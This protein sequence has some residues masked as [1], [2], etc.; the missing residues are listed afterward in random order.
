MYALGA[1][2]Q[3]EAR[4]FENHLGEQCSV[5]EEE[6]CS[7]IDAAGQIGLGVEIQSPPSYL[8]DLLLSRIEKEVQQQPLVIPFPER[9]ERYSTSET[10]TSSRR[11]YLRLAIAASLTLMAA[12]AILFWRQTVQLQS[13]IEQIKSADSSSLRLIRLDGQAAAPQS[14]GNIYWDTEKNRW[15]V[16]VTLPP[17]PEGKVYQLWFVTSDAKISAGLIRTDSEG[18]GAILVEVPRNINRLAAAAITLEPEG[19]SEQPTSPI[20]ASGNT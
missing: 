3:I 12:A 1:L 19:G 18:R 9:S 15:V 17:P 5:C 11:A 6:S 4:A 14:S 13:E 7:F 2:S 16:A 20:Y 8:R 10:A